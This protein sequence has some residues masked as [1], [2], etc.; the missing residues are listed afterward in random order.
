M[1]VRS[2]EETSRLFPAAD[3]A[4]GEDREKDGERKRRDTRDRDRSWSLAL[5]SARVEEREGGQA[6]VA[7]GVNRQSYGGPITIRRALISHNAP[8]FPSPGRAAGR[9][10]DGLHVADNGGREGRARADRLSR[11]LNKR[12]MPP[13]GRGFLPPPYASLCDAKFDA[14]RGDEALESHAARAG[15]IARHA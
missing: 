2:R 15:L 3:S 6:A 13:E 1:I 10:S 7:R 8:F 5:R 9:R 14:D 11:F 4:S 12:P